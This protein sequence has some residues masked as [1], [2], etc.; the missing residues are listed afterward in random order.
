MS[1]AKYREFWLEKWSVGYKCYTVKPDIN[2]THVI[3]YVALT[4]IEDKLEKEFNRRTKLSE[5]CGVQELYID[6]LKAEA[7][8]LIEAVEYVH[9]ETGNNVLSEAIQQFKS[10]FPERG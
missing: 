8:K 5:K 2:T 1:D 7:E 10:K 6:D 3:E 9:K 4:E